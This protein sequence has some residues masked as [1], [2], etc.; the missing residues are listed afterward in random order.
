VGA[1]IAGII[2][3]LLFPT[4]ALFAFLFPALLTG[5]PNPHWYVALLEYGVIGAFAAASVA[6]VLGSNSLHA[7]DRSKADRRANI[8]AIIFGSA[9]CSCYVLLVIIFNTSTFTPGP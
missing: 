2:A 5:W 8:L 7:P 9:S 1:L 3:I 4:P 6:L